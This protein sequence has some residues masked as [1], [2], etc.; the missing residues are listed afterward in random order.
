MPSP[1]KECALKHN[2]EVFQP[3]KIRN[4]NKTIFEKDV[5]LIVTAA[6][7]QMVPEKF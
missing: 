2:L 1:V 5:D 4:D 6:Y 3:E 7:G